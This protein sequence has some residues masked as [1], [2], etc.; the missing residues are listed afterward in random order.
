M[1]QEGGPVTDGG[2]SGRSAVA[3]RAAAALTALVV[4]LSLG[5]IA[6]QVVEEVRLGPVPSFREQACALPDAWL[7]R[8]RRGYYEPRS[9]QIALLPRTPAYMASGGDG[10][11]HSGPW[12]Y[13]Q[14]VPLVFFGPGIVPA[15][16][17][18][19]GRATTADVAPTLAALTGASFEAPDGSV[20]R[21]VVD[22][23]DAAAPRLVLTIVWD[24]GGWNT[25][26]MYDG[27][28]PN[29]A[30]LMARGVSYSDAT[31]G[32]S[33]SVTPAVHS[34]L[35]TG[36][37]PWLAGVTGVPVRDEEGEVVDAFLEG[38][39]SR[40]LQLP[41][42]AERWDAA[43]GHRARVGMLGYEPWHL[44]MVGQGAE[45]PGGDKD[46]A[47]WLDVE[48]NEW[49]TNPDH[50][51]LP[52]AV[53]SVRTLERHLSE[54]DVAD[55]AIDRAWRDNAILDA[56]DRVEETPAFVRFHTD[57]LL[58]LVDDGG[59]GDDRVTDLLFTNYKQI[60]R[61]GH[62]FNMA[63]PEVRD[64][65]IATDEELGR[66]VDFLDEEVGPGRYVVVVTADHGQQPDAA[67][68]G[69]FGID[70][71]EVERDLDAEF[72]PVSDA[73]WPTEVFLDDEAL[74]RYDV[75]VEE[76][77]TWLGDYRLEENAEDA[78]VVSGGDLSPTDRLF[79][80]AI[81]AR[82]LPGVECGG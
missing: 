22:R 19:T 71:N 62:Y 79:E 52:E 40:F 58:N 18:V 61:V 29:L 53:T 43:R 5:G 64:S 38:E 1:V 31:V 33:P 54:L 59:Y 23:P 13:L 56:P 63:S 35:G 11:S 66:I 69:G 73:V 80:L 74:E 3:R 70:P 36:A 20:L 10:W 82:M 24:G 72:G 6:V 44:G 77:A 55:G 46:D 42:F 28:W 17:D 49:I 41:T 9:G 37:Y 45:R 34:T 60:D 39:S 7:E 47:V 4:A 14:D 32:S 75:S 2:R 15:H 67:A 8:T 65:L 51:S 26:R 50:Y 78:D 57:A 68:V 16:G 12:P 76:V 27:D 21:E 48:T 30:R 25:L 81:P